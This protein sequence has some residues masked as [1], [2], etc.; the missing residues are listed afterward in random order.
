MAY[1]WSTQKKPLHPVFPYHRAKVV[2]SSSLSKVSEEF[3]REVRKLEVRLEDYLKDEEIFVKELQDCI[4]QFKS[5]HAPIEKL[6][7]HPTAE[8]IGEVVKLKTEGEEIFSEAVTNQGKAEHE[9]SHLLESYGALILALQKLENS[10][11][12][13]VRRT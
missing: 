5:L 13:D 10:L 12:S 6:G 1:R 7:A 8:K 4:V 3:Y 9:R 11:N 2:E